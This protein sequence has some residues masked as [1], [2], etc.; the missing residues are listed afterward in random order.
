MLC[1]HLLNQLPL[2]GIE[3]AEGSSV[4][5]HN[6]DAVISLV[7]FPALPVG[8]ECTLCGMGFD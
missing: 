6:F 4:I 1:I 8:F 5:P 2:Y 7:L 3:K